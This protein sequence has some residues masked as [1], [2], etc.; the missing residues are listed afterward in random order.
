MLAALTNRE[1]LRTLVQQ[2]WPHYRRLR[3]RQV[4]NEWVAH[5]P[6]PLL[7]SAQRIRSAVS[8]A[9]DTWSD[10]HD[11]ALPFLPA[12]APGAEPDTGPG[13]PWGLG[14][15]IAVVDEVGDL[16]RRALGVARETTTVDVLHQAGAA[17]V[18][19]Q[20]LVAVATRRCLRRRAPVDTA[21]APRSARAAAA[22]EHGP[23]LA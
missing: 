18:A 21:A 2:L 14:T 11:G 7:W 10:E 6:R 17:T 3:V 8:A 23:S 5:S 4:R 1:S 13:W 16:A 9:F 22:A 12:A 20:L 15:A 19:L